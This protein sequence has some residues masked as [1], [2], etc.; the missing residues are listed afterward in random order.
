M[1]NFLTTGWVKCF[2][3]VACPLLC[4]VFNFC[5]LFALLCYGC[6]PSVLFPE[7]TGDELHLDDIR[8]H[9][10]QFTNSLAVV[11][12]VEFYSKFMK[13]LISEYWNV[14]L[15]SEINSFH[16]NKKKE[17]GKKYT[18]ATGE[19][20]LSKCLPDAFTLNVIETSEDVKVKNF[21]HKIIRTFFF[22]KL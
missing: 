6:L 1:Y 10:S 4:V 9:A 11:E 21:I 7:N 2:C 3:V 15:F 13:S 5:K 20:L 16:C 8:S 19:T 14:D 12:S 22:D 18:D 17:I